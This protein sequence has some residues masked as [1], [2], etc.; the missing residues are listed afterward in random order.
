V[1]PRTVVGAA[2][3]ITALIFVA[4]TFARNYAAVPA[5][6][7]SPL[8]GLAVAAAIAANIAVVALGSRAWWQ[9]LRG[10]GESMSERRAFVICGTAQIGKYV[11]GNVFHLVGRAALAV[12]EGVPLPVAIASLTL[13]TMLIVIVGAVVASPLLY[14]RQAELRALLYP[15]MLALGLAVGA[16]LLVVGVVAW[17]FPAEG[18]AAQWCRARLKDTVVAAFRITNPRTLT[19]VVLFDAATFILLAGSLFVVADS[20]WPGRLSLSP[21]DCI[22]AFAL[23]WVLG[24]VTPGAPG[25]VGIREAVLL[26]ALGGTLGSGGAAAL[27]IVSR[28]L[29]IVGDVATFGVARA[30]DSSGQRLMAT[31]K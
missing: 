21:V 25:G 3:A 2:A 29:S 15:S 13:E 4:L 11:P 30:L 8:L 31:S 27:A 20:A 5:V 26:V 12:K 22:S 14:A 10:A 7:W 19:A 6:T 18:S 1:K 28:L 24:F 9:L 16:L 23:A 17:K